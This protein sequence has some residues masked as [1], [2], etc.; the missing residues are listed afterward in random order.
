[1]LRAHVLR[2]TTCAHSVPQ[3]LKIVLSH[4]TLGMLLGQACPGVHANH[5]L[6][7]MRHGHTSYTC[8]VC[9]VGQGTAVQQCRGAAAAQQWTWHRLAAVLAHWHPVLTGQ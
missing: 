4:A 8:A 5:A 6:T 9:G 3:Q 1:M 7:A 2:A